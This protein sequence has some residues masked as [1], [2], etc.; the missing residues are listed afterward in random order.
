MFRPI[1]AC[2]SLNSLVCVVTRLRLD[3]GQNKALIRSTKKR[4]FFPLQS[5]QT[6]S[7]FL[8]VIN[9][10]GTSCHFPVVKAAEAWVWLLIV[11]DRDQ[12]SV[13]LHLHSHVLLHVLNC[14]KFIFIYIWGK[15]E[16]NL[17]NVEHTR[18]TYTP[19]VHTLQS[20]FTYRWYL[21]SAKS[22]AVALSN[23]NTARKSFHTTHCEIQCMIKKN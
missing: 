20:Y 8:L 2:N 3:N 23:C 15:P 14:D 10:V 12:E 18:I 19:K 16:N 4:F 1:S 17:H 11:Y 7:R 21:V 6:V 13:E 5:I 9:F 22:H